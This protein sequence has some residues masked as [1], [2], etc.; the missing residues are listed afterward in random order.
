MSQSGSDF[1]R[2]P[3]SSIDVCSS[4]VIEYNNAQPSP[5]D[6]KIIIIIIIIKI[7]IIIITIIMMMMIIAL[8]GTI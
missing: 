8:K 2:H 7:I 5:E 6:L 3:F 1:L 4:L